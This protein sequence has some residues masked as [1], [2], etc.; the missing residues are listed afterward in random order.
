MIDLSKATKLKEAVFEFCDSSDAQAAW[1][2]KTITP[3]H[4]DFQ[5]ISIHLLPHSHTSGDVR[6]AVG[7][8]IYYQWMDLDNTLVRLSDSHGIRMK[9]TISQLYNE[10]PTQEDTEA[11]RQ[12]IEGLLPQMAEKGLID[13]A[14]SQVTQ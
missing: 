9:V 5:Q 12:Q 13:A 14:Y 6:Q 11:V 10:E 4:Q 1:I 8:E 2:T 3:G 7:E